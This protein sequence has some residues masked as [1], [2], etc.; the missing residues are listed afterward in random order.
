MNPVSAWAATAP[1]DISEGKLLTEKQLDN[2]MLSV[3]ASQTALW[4]TAQWPNG[5]RVGFRAVFALG[6]VFE[7]TKLSGED[8]GQVKIEIQCRLGKYDVRLQLPESESAVFR[9]TTIFTP[10]EDLF[11]P[12]SPHDVVPLPES[13]KVGEASGEVHVTQ[14]GTRSGHL[15][16]SLSKPAT[17]S[18]F[19]FQ[20]LT[21]LSEYC[22][23][24]KTSAGGS[25]GGT[26]PEMG[27]RLPAAIEQPLPGGKTV[28]L[29]DAFVLLTEEVPKDIAQ[30][31]IKYLDYLAEI[32]LLLPRPA[33]KYNNWP[34][35]ASKGLED[36]R[37]NKGCWTQAEGK[38]FLN[39]YVCDYDTPPEIMVQL[40]VLIPVTEYFE[41]K[42][43]TDK[44]IDDIKE[45]LPS[46]FDEK[47]KT[48]RRWLPSQA[49]R[50]DNSEEQKTEGV[51]DAWYLHHPL[52]N[53]SR[54]ALRK[55]KTAEKLLL[56][57]LG[58]TM[59]VAKHFKYE[60]PVFYKM[61]T[62][63]V[64]KA[65]IAPGKGGE[66]DVPGAYAHLMLQAWDVT[67]DSKYFDEAVEAVKKLEGVGFEIFYQANNTAFAAATLLRLYKETKD[68]KY[69][70][71]SYTCLACL[72]RNMQLW[73][74]NYG[75]SKNYSRFFSIYPLSDAPYIAPYEELEVYA[76]LFYYLKQSADIDLRPSVKLLIAEFIRYFVYRMPFYYPTVL[77]EEVLSEEVKTGEIDR[78]LWIPLEDLRDGWEK[79]GQVGQEVY[80]AAGAGF[81]ILPRQ[82]FK[83]GDETTLLFSDYPVHK[84]RTAK[85]GSATFEVKGDAR[86][87][88]KI[89]LIGEKLR[90]K[91]VTLLDRGNKNNLE[92]SDSDKGWVEFTVR[93]NSRLKM[94]WERASNG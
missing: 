8:D 83:F 23:A 35:I 18:V 55:D 50:L 9:Y 24:T 51:M 30:V 28:T 57:S 33:T 68:E 4:I 19:Y 41:W 5:G 12:F 34:E 2:Y 40:A 76:A 64:L 84:F 73:E 39:A 42:G 37:N 48:I 13:G 22:D 58:F 59:N 52:M 11:I 29:S 31:A 90:A 25:V 61:E 75:Y 16:F 65:E 53:L 70:E 36:L 80:G 62:L 49:K 7:T 94:T 71:L 32:Y 69:M 3:Y 79:S 26:W 93:G 82:Y 63:E 67:G 54:L 56:D 21:A 1:F 45:G 43:G 47:L 85:D 17:G 10:Q 87:E 27:L 46:F 72:F 81:G 6:A 74:G 60:W 15:Y 77:P 14:Q 78:N 38:S 92:F 44:L 86:L 89:R 66:K 20:N 91:Q 88:C